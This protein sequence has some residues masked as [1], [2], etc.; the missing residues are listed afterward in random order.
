MQRRTHH[1]WLVAMITMALGLVLGSLRGRAWACNKRGPNLRETWD[2]EI[3]TVEIEGTPNYAP[4]FV[5]GASAELYRLGR[6]RNELVVSNPGL[7][8]AKESQ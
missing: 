8:F 1:G 3:R 5:Q 4:G 7:I 6:K 2:L